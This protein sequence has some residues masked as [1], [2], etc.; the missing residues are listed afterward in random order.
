MY[1]TVMEAKK[2]HNL[3]STSWRTTE[4]G[5]IFQPQS[6]GLRMGAGVGAYEGGAHGVSPDMSLKVQEPGTLLSEGK[7]RWTSQL[8]QN[9]FTLPQPFC[10]IQAL[11][12]LDETPTLGRAI[13]FT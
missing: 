13:C 10:S 4:A 11:N 3:P 1:H 2:S 6:K 8:K 7:R 12:R 5:G 9:E